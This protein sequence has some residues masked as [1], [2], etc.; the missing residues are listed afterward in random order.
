MEVRESLIVERL[1]LL[2]LRADRIV[3][4]ADSGAQRDR[5]LRNLDDGGGGWRRRVR[6]HRLSEHSDQQPSHGISHEG[7]KTPRTLRM[8]CVFGPSC[9]SCLR[10]DKKARRG[11]PLRAPL[12]PMLSFAAFASFATFATFATF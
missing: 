9:F 12:R 7:T 5:T 8:Y 4:D 2:R 11:V 3:S 10:G 1:R 6:M